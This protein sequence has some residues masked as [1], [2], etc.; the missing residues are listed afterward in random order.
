[1]RIFA[2]GDIHGLCEKLMELINKIPLEDEDLLI[3]LGDYI[4]RGDENK[5]VIDY[6]IQLK[7]NRRDGLTVFLKGNHEVMFLDYLQG[8]NIELFF[9]NG[10]RETVKDYT[11]N[12]ELFIPEDHLDFFKNLLPYYETESYIFVHGGLKPGVSLDNQSEDDLF[13]IRGDFIFSDYNFGKKIIFGHTPSKTFMPYYD[14]YKIGI[15]TGAI[16]GGT[17]SAIM[18]PDEKIFSV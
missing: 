10:G 11:S 15:D 12:G 4:D 14:K 8:R 13:W 17:L 18:L 9:Y 16:Y 5:K 7:K 2:V 1:M 3:F 6:L